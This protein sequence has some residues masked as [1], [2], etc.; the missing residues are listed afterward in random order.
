MKAWLSSGLLWRWRNAILDDVKERTPLSSP[1]FLIEVVP[2]KGFF[3]RRRDVEG[4]ASGLEW[5][6]YI[7]G[8]DAVVQK[9]VVVW[10]T[11]RIG[12]DDEATV[13]LSGMAD[14][15]TRWVYAQIFFAVPGT[16]A[17]LT[18][19]ADKAV[20]DP[21]AAIVRRNLVQVKRTGDE[22]TLTGLTAHAGEIHFDGVL[23][24]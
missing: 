13:D 8:S 15:D 6:V 20:S 7:S 9:G 5:S 2:G 17:G 14:E 18:A 12:T 24:P 10:G 21:N 3:I 19:D 22:Y 23:A 1:D 11:V 16:G 4:Q